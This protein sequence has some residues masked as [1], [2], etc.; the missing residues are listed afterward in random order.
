MSSTIEKRLHLTRDRADRLG[1]LAAQNGTTEDALV[2]KALDI[3]FSVSDLSAS[4]ER[5]FWADASAK[6]FARVWDN[7]ADARYDI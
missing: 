4:D 5:R 2:E 6:S 7:E 1:K 3:L